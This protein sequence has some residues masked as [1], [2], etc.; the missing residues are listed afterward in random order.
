MTADVAQL[1]EELLLLQEQVK[2]LE[3]ELKAHT[4]EESKEGGQVYWAPL[5]PPTEPPEPPNPLRIFMGS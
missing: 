1:R 3:A 4:K 2:R 5:N